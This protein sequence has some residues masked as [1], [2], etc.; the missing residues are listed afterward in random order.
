[1]VRFHP[2]SDTAMDSF[3]MAPAAGP[4]A[5]DDRDAVAASERERDVDHVAGVDQSSSGE[6]RSRD[7]LPPES[8]RIYAETLARLPPVQEDATRELAE[9]VTF[10]FVERRPKAGEQIR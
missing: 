4:S 10:R 8:I 2:D 7:G 5:G 1:M 6:D 9:E 3:G